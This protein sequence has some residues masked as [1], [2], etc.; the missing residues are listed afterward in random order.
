ML[1][2]DRC[3]IAASLLSMVFAGMVR[4]LVGVVGPGRHIYRLSR[5]SPRQGLAGA[6]VAGGEAIVMGDLIETSLRYR[7]PIGVPSVR[8]SP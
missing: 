3:G 8:H 2:P 4:L 5:L 7:V 6:G 1:I